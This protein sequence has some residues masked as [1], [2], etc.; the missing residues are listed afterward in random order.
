M[1]GQQS[2]IMPGSPLA[3]TAMFTEIVRERFRATNGLA[4]VW[5]ENANPAATETND[6]GT[7]TARKIQIEPAFNVNTDV[8]NYR[9]SI[10][11]DK[12]ETVSGKV[13]LGNFAGQKLSTAYKGF[14]ALA[15][16]PID[17]ECVSDQRGE[18]A[19]IADITWFYILAGREQIL[20]T[21]GM[22]DLTN[23]TLS[24]TMPFETDKNSWSTHITFEVQL[25]LRWTTLPISPLLRDIV[26]RYH[27]SGD[28]DPDTFFLK[29]YIP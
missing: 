17:I 13:A 15:T 19:Q 14:Y 2:D 25:H 4:W 29:T 27:Q 16:V 21:F 22:H 5:D 8:R 28:S 12:G 10:F 3:I 20:Q 7:G 26:T 6:P 18:C 24:R 1:P 23:P 9:P 11:I